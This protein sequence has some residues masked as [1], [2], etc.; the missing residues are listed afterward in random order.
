MEKDECTCTC[1]YYLKKKAEIHYHRHFMIFICMKFNVL[2]T[3]LENFVNKQ[4]ILTIYAF[5][6]YVNK[7]AG[8]T[9]TWQQLSRGPNHTFNL[10]IT[11][12][13]DFLIFIVHDITVLVWRGT[14]IDTTIAVN[15]LR[16]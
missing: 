14:R 5:V 15:Q 2:R 9:T 12:R 1:M 13:G 16:Y 11:K 10:T 3:K 4:I 6:L 7:I 8:N